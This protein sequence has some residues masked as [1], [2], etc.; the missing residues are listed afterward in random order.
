MLL[1]LC[2]LASRRARASAAPKIAPDLKRSRNTPAME[3]VYTS[4]AG[5]TG[6]PFMKPQAHLFTLLLALLPALTA[7]FATGA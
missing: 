5:K 2:N 4:L 3:Q 6:G 1:P 7:L